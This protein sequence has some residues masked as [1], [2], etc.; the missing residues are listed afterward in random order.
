M[1]VRT[2]CWVDRADTSQGGQDRADTPIPD[3]SPQGGREMVPRSASEPN[4]ASER[5]SGRRPRAEPGEAGEIAVEGDPLAAVLDGEGGEPG[6][7]HFR[8]D[9]VGLDA[10]ASERSPKW[11]ST[12]RRYNQL[13][14]FGVGA[15]RDW[16]NS[17]D[18]S[19]VLGSR[20]HSP[21]GGY[22]H[23]SAERQRRNAE[24][25][26]T[27][28]GLRQPGTAGRVDGRLDPKRVDQDVDVRQDHLRSRRRLT[29]SASS[30]SSTSRSV[31]NGGFS[32]PFAELTGMVTGRKLVRGAPVGD[33]AAQALLDQRRQGAAFGGG[34]ALGLN[35]QFAWQSDGSAVGHAAE[36]ACRIAVSS[37]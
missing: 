37:C 23:Q 22:A 31:L 3:P 29:Y 28:Y 36:D 17:N 16:Q 1:G 2:G 27:G 7:G 18:S 13:V 21:I 14:Q 33:H 8:P 6:V 9:N 34:F 4:V 10:E 35:Q 11:R 25:R 20:T 24:P 26:L 30:N 5:E 12:R 32:Q 19:S 15:I